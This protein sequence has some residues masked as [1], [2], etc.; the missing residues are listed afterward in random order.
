M[1]EAAVDQPSRSRW[2]CPAMSSKTDGHIYPGSH[3]PWNAAPLFYP[4]FH[5]RPPLNS[6]LILR[7]FRLTI[8]AS[9]GPFASHS[10]GPFHP[11]CFTEFLD[12]GRLRPKKICNCSNLQQNVFRIRNGTTHRHMC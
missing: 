11:M 8:N 12:T 7:S 6:R 2:H 5:P 4:E 9:L 10:Y 1:T 3:P